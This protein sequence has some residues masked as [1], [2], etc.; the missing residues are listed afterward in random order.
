MKRTEK[1]ICFVTTISATINAFVRDQAHYLEQNG[2]DVTCICHAPDT[3]PCRVTATIQ[4]INIAMSRG[5]NPFSTMMAIMQLYTICKREKFNIIQYSTPKAAFCAGTAAWLAGIPVR[6]YA[7]WGIRYVGFNGIL[8][9]FF[10]IF[11]RW[12]CSCSTIIEPDSVSNLQF[13]INEGLYAPEKGRVIWNGSAKGVNFT[14]FDIS[15]K[16]RWRASYQEKIGIE[17]HQVVVG[18]VGSIRRDKGCNELLAAC[19]SLFSRHQECC[20]LLVGD[21]HFNDTIEKDLHAWMLNS[22]QVFI[23]PPTNEIEKY[24]AC[25]DVLCLPSY[26]EGFGMVLVEAQALGIPVV[27]SN[28]PG[29]VDAMRHEQTGFAVPVRDIVSLSTALETVITDQALREAMGATAVAFVRE[30]FAQETLLQKFL[31]DKEQL[32]AEQVNN[33]EAL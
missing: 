13:S 18:F 14:Q 4:V 20:L 2:W 22:S 10:K 23:L 27:A 25:M 3:N 19:R 21:D 9:L 6:L 28:I 17:P 29:P 32:L 12:C 31:E 26:R 1:K 8:R 16:G 11:E 7:Q 5:I 33:R 15:N 30:H 24:M